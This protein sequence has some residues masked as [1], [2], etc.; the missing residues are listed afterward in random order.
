MTDAQ[1]KLDELIYLSD[2][3]YELKEALMWVDEQALKKGISMLQMMEIILAKKMNRKSAKEWV[4]NLQNK[5]D[6]V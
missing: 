1:E 6:K 3:D 4:Q 2:H 5:Y